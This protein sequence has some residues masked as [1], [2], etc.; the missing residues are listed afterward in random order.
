M[1]YHPQWGR[2]IR[3]IQEFTNG[4]AVKDYF[5]EIEAGLRAKGIVQS[6]AK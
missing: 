6:V 4:A 3:W 1:K 5:A 2:Y